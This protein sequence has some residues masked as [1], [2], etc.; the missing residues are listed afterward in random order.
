MTPLRQFQISSTRFQVL[1]ITSRLQ[2]KQDEN[3]SNGLHV[4]LPQKL[5]WE[6]DVRRRRAKLR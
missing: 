3:V 6:T 1:R 5:T 4:R 2:M